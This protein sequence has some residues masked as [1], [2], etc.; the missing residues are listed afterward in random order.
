MYPAGDPSIHVRFVTLRSGLRVRVLECGVAT[1]PA[2]VLLHGWCC[3]AYT[4]RH[5][6]CTL[7]DAGCRV[8]LAD[9]KGHG[10]SD[11]PLG[12]GEYTLARMAEHAVEVMDAVGVERAMLVG[13]SMGGAVAV[14][15]ALRHPDRVSRLVLLAPAGFGAVSVLPVAQLLTPRLVTPLLPRRVRR[16]TIAA[17][18][19]L[20]YG[21][22]GRI[23][24]RDVDEYFA[25][26]QFPA[27]ALAMRELLHDFQWAPG[28][29]GEL[30]R[31]GVQT[32]VMF[33]TRDLLV[34]TPSV[35]AMVRA[36][37][38]AELDVIEGAGHVLPE[39]AAERVNA[40]LARFIAAGA[41]E[42][43]PHLAAAGATTA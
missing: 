11:K 15:V 39:E 6:L 3:S 16:W 21:R 27:F 36:I 8:V 33:G 31:I 34:Y 4:Y 40:Q 35:A 41:A 14:E 24:A 20:A 23:T 9:L 18:L 7:T 2:V 12:R 30:E 22:G 1:G 42:A 26:T 37:P 29:P 43:S 10:L 17:V 28:E 38:R 5:N 32:L 25:P 13:H 19:R